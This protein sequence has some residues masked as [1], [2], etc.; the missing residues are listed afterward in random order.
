MG[1]H[2]SQGSDPVSLMVLMGKRDFPSVVLKYRRFGVA[3]FISTLTY[4]ICT[5]FPLNS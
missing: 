5:V 1:C 3:S 2:L 4:T